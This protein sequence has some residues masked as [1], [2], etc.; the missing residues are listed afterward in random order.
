[1]TE[2]FDWQML[3]FVALAII[4][5]L[6]ALTARQLSMKKW[7]VMGLAWLAI[8]AVATLFINLVTGG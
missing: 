4:L 1:M 5:P 6:S 3:V 8:F 2:T 7:V